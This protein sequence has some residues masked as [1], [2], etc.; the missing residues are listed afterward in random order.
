[1]RKLTLAFLALC[2][3]FSVALTSCKKPPV[4]EVKP[5]LKEK[6]QGTT[7]ILGNVTQGGNNKN[8]DFTGFFIRFSADGNQVTVKTGGTNSTEFTSGCSIGTNTVNITT[9]PAGTG[10]TVLSGF[11]TRDENKPTA[12]IKFDVAIINAKTGSANFNFD[13]N[14]Q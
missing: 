4:E 6:I 14:K 5:T 2:L 9:P 11:S 3:V 1:M 10:W 12:G 8:S 13:L 7:Y